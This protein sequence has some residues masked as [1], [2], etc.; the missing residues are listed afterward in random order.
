MNSERRAVGVHYIDRTTKAHNEARAKIIVLAAA[1]LESTRILL[2]T[3]SSRFPD[4][5]GNS[6]GVLGHYLMDHFTIEGAGGELASLKSSKREEVGN[7]CGYL[8]AKY[9]NIEG[10]KNSNFLRG[11]RFDGSA[12]QEL[13]GQAFSL[14]GYGREWR[15]KVRTEIP[16]S[17]S[18]EAQGEC[19]PRF[20]NFVELDPEKKDAWGIPVLRIHASYGENE[21]TMAKAMRQDIGN[22][23]D[24]MKIQNPVP[25]DQEL[26]VFGKNIHEC[27]T[28][29]MG[30]DPKKSVLNAYNKV[31]DAKNVFVT[32]G[33]SFVTQGCYEPTLTIMAI[34]V[35]ASDYIIDSYRKGEL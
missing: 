34:S 5:V 23:L 21:H 15:E 11:Y 32:D 33:A 24:A 3:R 22:I 35:R 17:F 28:A 14:P 30:T 8:I 1:T 31:H 4:G 2:N 20:D 16:Y 19:L 26:S 29:R 7:P 25:P 12:N 27:G 6:N 13:Y 18:V 10:H 9:S